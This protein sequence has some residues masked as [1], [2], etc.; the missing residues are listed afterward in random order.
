MKRIILLAAMA[1]VSAMAFVSCTTPASVQQLAGYEYSMKLEKVVWYDEDEEAAITADMRNALGLNS[2]IIKTYPNNVDN[3]MISACNAVKE[4]Y[5][6][7]DLK[8]VYLKYVLYRT[9]VNTATPQDPAAIATYEFGDALKRPWVKFDYASNNAEVYAAFEKVMRDETVMTRDEAI[10]YSHGMKVLENDWSNLWS[11]KTVKDVFF[12]RPYA[13]TEANTESM[14]EWGEKIYA[15]YYANDSYA[16]YMIWD[17][18]TYKI[19]KTNVISGEQAQIWEKTWAKTQ[20]D[21]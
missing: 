10:L 16:T 15:D 9:I 11:G 4:K 20:R 17:D 21:K 14:K 13:D 5:D 2:Q 18:I 7:Q 6:A 3:Q 1:A 19:V 8:T 12:T